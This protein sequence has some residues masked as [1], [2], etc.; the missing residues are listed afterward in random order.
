MWVDSQG[1]SY[2][3]LVGVQS[4]RFQVCDC[5]GL[6]PSFC[7]KVSGVTTSCVLRAVLQTCLRAAQPQA[8]RG[9]RS[10]VIL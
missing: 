4:L 8:A 9:V 6:Q 7:P 1:Y 2:Q 3:T 5:E 10:A